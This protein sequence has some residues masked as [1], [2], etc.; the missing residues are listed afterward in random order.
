MMASMPLRDVLS[1]P[2]MI[3]HKSRNFNTTLVS[4]LSLFN[5]VFPILLFRH[6]GKIIQKVRILIDE[7][8]KSKP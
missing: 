5:Q 1:V 6:H 4:R 3:D 8:L 7:L 2:M